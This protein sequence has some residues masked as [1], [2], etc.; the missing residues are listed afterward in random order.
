MRSAVLNLLK[1]ELS[2]LVGLSKDALHVHLGLLVFLLAMV[3]FRRS[4]ASLLPW[5]C[6]LVLQLAN[7]AVDTLHWHQGVLD[8]DLGDSF[9]DIIN[10]MLWPT[11]ILLL[12]R[13]TGL[14]KRGSDSGNGPDVDAATAPV[15][16]SSPRST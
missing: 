9:K 12:A 16:D 5:T 11:L 8:F 14:L 13:F 2:E 3:I 10:T 15:N 4:A 1:T 7:E 6:V